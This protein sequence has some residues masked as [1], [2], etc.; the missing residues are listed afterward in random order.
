MLLQQMHVQRDARRNQSTEEPW[1]KKTHCLIPSLADEEIVPQRR[2]KRLA[3]IEQEVVDTGSSCPV[4]QSAHMRVDLRPVFV[5]HI[6]G[7]YFDCGFA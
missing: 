2:I 3:G 4:A 6:V 7:S 1:R 5:L